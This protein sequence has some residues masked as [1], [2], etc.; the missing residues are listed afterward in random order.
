MNFQRGVMDLN[1]DFIQFYQH[2]KQDSLENVTL[3]QNQIIGRSI[4]RDTN[5]DGGDEL[6]NSPMLQI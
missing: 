3:Q 4:L 6:N 1:D 2:Y 5:E